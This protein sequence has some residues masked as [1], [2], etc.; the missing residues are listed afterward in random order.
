MKKIILAIILLMPLLMNAQHKFGSVKAGMFTPGATETGFILGYEGGWIIDD[1]VLV[2]W[3]ADWFNKNYVD[4]KLVDQFNEFYGIINY[5][6]NELR[7][8]TNLHSF[9]LMGSINGNWLIAPRTRAFVTGAAGI[10]VLLIF[11]KNYANPNNNEFQGAFDFAWRLGTGV[12]Y[13]L[14]SRSDAFF[15]LGYHRSQPSWE[16]EVKDDLGRRKILE[17]R[18]DMSGLLLRAG[19]RFYF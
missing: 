6:L 17:R 13:E 19:I 9:P 5:Q 3:S 8:K 7:A 1:N 4:R 18:F 12:M 2:G 11:Y 15:E 10:E 14:G 16:Y